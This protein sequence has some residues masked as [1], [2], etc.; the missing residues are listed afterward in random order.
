MKRPFRLFI[1]S[2]FALF[3]TAWW[4]KGFIL[5]SHALPFVE[6]AGILT[7]IFL[8]INPLAKIVL[9]PLNL[10]TFGFFSL[11]LYIF[12]IHLLTTSFHLFGLT[13]WQFPGMSLSIFTIPSMHLNYLANLV[14]SS[15]SLSSIINTL[16]QFT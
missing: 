8:V 5:P 12:F 1:F 10:F 14:L 11:V 15:L 16:D 7:L 3:I 9:F 6:L 2:L 13:A 4:N